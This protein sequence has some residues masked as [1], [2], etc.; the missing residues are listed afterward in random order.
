MSLAILILNWNRAEDTIHCVRS[1]QA[2]RQ[3][4]DHIWVIDNNSAPEDRAKLRQVL[5]DEVIFIFSPANLGFA[6]GNNLGL[7]AALA[8]EHDTVLL[9]NNDATVDGTAVTKLLTL[10]QTHPHLGMV[11]PELWDGEQMLSAGGGDIG[12]TLGTHHQEPLANSE[13]R[14]VAYI[15]GTCIFI[16]TAVLQQVGL[17]DEDY[18]FGGEVADLCARVRQAGF[19]AAV[20]GGTRAQH[21]VERSA[22]QRHQLHIYYVL[23]NRFLYVQKF[24]ASQRLRLFLYWSLISGHIWL[25]ALLQRNWPR[26][27][28]AVLACWDG[29]HG[30][31][32]G[33]NAR[34]TRGKIR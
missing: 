15:P 20:L 5:Q 10:L 33:Q 22:G 7:Q 24:H 25:E 34:V 6:G 31:F 17:L 16:R 14:E 23:R 26:A 4:E 13:M 30:R 1:V 19:G 27:R 12:L 28:A 18:F 32:G 8:T 9:L 3:P 21:Q 29:W 2:W 11:G